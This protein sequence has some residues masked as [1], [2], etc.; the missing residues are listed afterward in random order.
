MVKT[1]T[2]V[3]GGLGMAGIA[4]LYY[5]ARKQSSQPVVYGDE[6]GG[7]SPVDDIYYAPRG[8]EPALP[9]FPASVGIPFSPVGS[10]SGPILSTPADDATPPPAAPEQPATAPDCIKTCSN[11]PP[12]QSPF[13][14][15]PGAD[16]MKKITSFAEQFRGRFY[17]PQ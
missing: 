14:G 5:I 16:P 4:I 15:S 2:I 6:F 13:K 12:S 9:Y 10:Y 3:V 11:C 8:E 7:A 17:N 1:E